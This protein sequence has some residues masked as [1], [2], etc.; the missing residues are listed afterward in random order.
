VLARSCATS[1]R[2]DV[3]LARRGLERRPSTGLGKGPEG[4]DV[5]MGDLARTERD[6]A[7]PNVPAEADPAAEPRPTEPTPT[8]GTDADETSPAKLGKPVEPSPARGA[9]PRN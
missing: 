4:N 8:R 2:V 3:P 5:A 6:P 7:E 1:C 9:R